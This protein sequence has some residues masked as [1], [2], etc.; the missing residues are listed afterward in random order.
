MSTDVQEE[1]ITDDSITITRAQR[2]TVT[3]ENI[4]IDFTAWDVLNENN[5]KILEMVPG[6]YEIA[7][8]NEEIDRQI[9]TYVGKTGNLQE[10][11]S[12]HCFGYIR[13]R[14]GKDFKSNI[15]PY[16]ET[17]R[18]KGWVTLFRVFEMKDE[19][20]AKVREE[21]LLERY[22]YLW[23]RDV[24]DK[25]RVRVINYDEVERDFWK[26]KAK[27]LEEYMSEVLEKLSVDMSLLLSTKSLKRKLP[28]KTL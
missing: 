4:K 12:T 20:C 5:V 18:N 25:F 1:L 17:A 15:F 9:V 3:D 2:E 19:S 16:I 6:I 11:L 23:N 7:V 24:D 8:Y 28:T 27:E 10:R 26:H 22:D 13:A 14:C 21:Y